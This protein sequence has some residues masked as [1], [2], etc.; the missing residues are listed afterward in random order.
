MAASSP[1]PSGKRDVSARRRRDRHRKSVRSE[2]RLFAAAVTLAAG[3]AT[4]AHAQPGERVR[5]DRFE[6][7]MTEV[8][9]AQFG[10][11]ARAR[12]LLTEA[13]K[14]GGGFEWGAGWEKRQ[15]WAYQRP[16]GDVAHPD[17]PAVHVSWHEA[18]A[19]C[20]WAGGRLPTFEE[21]RRAAYTE[22]RA[23]PSDGFAAG[24]TYAYPVGDTP[25]GL[26]INGA[27]PWPLHAR[28]GSTRRGVNGLFDMGGNV[29]EW[30][31][32]RRGA[33]ALTAGGSWWYGAAQATAGGAQWKP[34]D[35]FAVYVGLRCAYDPG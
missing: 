10:A 30:T 6:I 23:T 1:G 29:W 7:D 21:W 3:L 5:I 32:D 25:D 19:Y 33:E 34:A 20:R 31:A 27:D 12:S 11:F 24:R 17:E 28:V 22:T 13:E 15:G 35:F 16:Y 14:T 4:G 26:N 18:D 2:G 9:V 8:T